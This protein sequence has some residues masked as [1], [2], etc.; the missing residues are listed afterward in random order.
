MRAVSLQTGVARDR[1]R[2]KHAGRVSWA[3]ALML[4][5]VVGACGGDDIV[6]GGFIPTL[7]PRP[8]PTVTPSLGQPGDPCNRSIDCVSG[9]CD[10]ATL[11]C[12]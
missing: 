9:I 2:R 3:V 1:T 11:T 7:P 5:T 8:T 12:R 4:C 10:P 6:V